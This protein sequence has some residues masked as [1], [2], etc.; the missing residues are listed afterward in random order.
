MRRT[1]AEPSERH[2]VGVGELAAVSNHEFAWA[3]HVE[4][5][6][7]RFEVDLAEGHGQGLFEGE[8]DV[9]TG[10]RHAVVPA[11]LRVQAYV[12][13]LHVP[14]QRHPVREPS[15]EPG[16]LVA[17]PDQEPL[18]GSAKSW[19]VRNFAAGLAGEVRD[20]HAGGQHQRA[21][22]GGV[23]VGVLEVLEV[24]AVLQ[25]V[26]ERDAVSVLNLFRGDAPGSGRR[27]QQG[28]RDDRQFETV[29]P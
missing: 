29:T 12:Q 25:L 18:L 27:R 21:A 23:G 26:Q 7:P 28:V 4:R 19:S 1:D 20:V 5:L 6:E 24:G 13:R 15:V 9:A 3:Y 22:L 11:R 2:Q 14:T 10:H 16:Q 8:L 17:G